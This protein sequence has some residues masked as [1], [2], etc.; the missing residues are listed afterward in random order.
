[1]GGLSLHIQHNGRQ[2]LFD[3]G[4]T[5][6]FGH[7]ADRKQADRFE[8]VDELIEISSDVFILTEIGHP[9][10]CCAPTGHPFRGGADAF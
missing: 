5:D 1:M 7:N 9:Y 6:T 3:T 2:I 10:P 4:A 8:F